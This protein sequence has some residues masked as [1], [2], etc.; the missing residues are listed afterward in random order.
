MVK[1]ITRAARPIASR[2]AGGRVRW[3]AL[4]FVAL[5]A[6]TAA[7]A[8]RR[9]VRLEI[10]APEVVR[11]LLEK[12]LSI[13]ADGADPGEESQREALARQ[14]RAE[15]AEL[16]ATEGYFSPQVELFERDGEGPARL[17][18]SVRPGARATVSEVRIEFT[19]AIA[20]PAHAG[21]V[22]ALRAD[23]A[24]PAGR[25]FRQEDWSAAKR[26][27][28]GQLLARDFAAAHLAHS[29]A[30]VDAAAAGVRLSLSYD[31][32]PA[33]A[34][35]ELRLSG[36]DIY[37][38]DLV[39]RF[40]DLSPGEPYDQE[41]LLALQTRLQNTPYFSSVVV[42]VDAQAAEGGRL[43]VQVQLR[44]AKPRRFGL[45]AGYSTNTGYRGEMLYGD[46]NLFGRGWMFST[47]LRLEQTRS[48][49]Y[50][51]VLL[52]PG[53]KDYRDSFGVLAETDEIQGLETTRYGAGAA[54]TRVQGRIE[55]QLGL[56]LHRERKRIAGVE[57]AAIEALTANWS[58]TYR[59]VDNPLDPRRGYTW[60][61]QA[62][63]G[64]KALLSERNF[65]R[66]YTRYQRFLPV[67]ARHQLILRGEFGLTAAA[68][69]AGIPESFL[70]RTGGAQ[71]VRG[72]AFQSL[73]TRQDGAV[74]GGRRL[75]TASAEYVHWLD[76]D[77]GAAF[78][79]DVGDAGD[80]RED[81]ELRSGLGLGARWRSPAGPLALDLAYGVRDGRVRPHFSVSIA[82]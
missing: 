1:C 28:L 53:A 18:L 14:A 62:G 35:G 9:P 21:R 24:L 34:L 58:W 25:P 50:A 63:G 26:K 4:A 3:C 69:R 29:R 37:P 68:A 65:L 31:S 55:T 45:G 12:H 51:D 13:L 49:A 76:G 22:A 23:W 48:F 32:G 11:G 36:L 2:R 33:F 43:P 20:E 59:D 42:D 81:F 38:E 66:G 72:Y 82:F 79:Y 8:E 27:L 54:R 30:E 41:R 47:G 10:D 70:F 60:N 77:W 17:V 6:A 7:A 46:N 74:V 44:E 67:G 64:A 73:G 39:D 16:L 75:I 61:L 5:V 80:S 40:S 71:S 15:A 57:S 78:F 56:N 19:G 52:P